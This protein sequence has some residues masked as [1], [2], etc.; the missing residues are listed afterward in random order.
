MKVINKF[1]A[2]EGKVRGES[3]SETSA[4]GWEKALALALIQRIEFVMM[5]FSVMAL[6]SRESCTWNFR[7]VIERETKTRKRMISM[8]RAG[9]TKALELSNSFQLFPSKPF[10]TAKSFF[11]HV[12]TIKAFA[13]DEWVRARGYPDPVIYGCASAQAR[14]LA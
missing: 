13:D 4:R 10:T 14:S 2:H 6:A 3:E 11:A 7:H 1:E 8:R 5:E 9:F 12:T